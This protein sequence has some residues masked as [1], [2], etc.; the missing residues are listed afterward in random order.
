MRAPRVSLSS[1]ALFRAGQHGLDTATVI[2]VARFPDQRFPADHG[3][4]VRQSLVWLAARKKLQLIRLIVELRDAEI[5]V[6]TAYPT[7]KISRYW[8]R[9]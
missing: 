5:L 6:V 8:R 1:H 9:A 2:D 4:E 7:S 3:R